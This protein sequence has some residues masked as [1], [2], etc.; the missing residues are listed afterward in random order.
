MAKVRIIGLLYLLIGVSANAV[1]SLQ[2][3]RR[4]VVGSSPAEVNCLCDPQLIVLSLV[5]TLSSL[6]VLH[7][8]I[9]Y[10]DDI[11]FIDRRHNK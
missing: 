5:V 9:I 6:I 11:T 4:S 2:T 8:F 1:A 3:P 10:T 7:S